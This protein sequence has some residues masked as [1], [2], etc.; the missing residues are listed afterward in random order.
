MKSKG[1]KIMD[2]ELIADCLKMAAMCSIC[3]RAD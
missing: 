3:K 1:F 2:T